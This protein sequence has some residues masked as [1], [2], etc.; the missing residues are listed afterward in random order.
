MNDF[1]DGTKFSFGKVELAVIPDEIEPDYQAGKSVNP[2]KEN[3]TQDILDRKMKAVD[4]LNNLKYSLPKN[5]IE[6]N[7][8]TI[9]ESLEEMADKI[10]QSS[11]ETKQYREKSGRTFK[12][13][14][15]FH[16]KQK[17]GN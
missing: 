13:K 4:A 14:T 6:A 17:R 15:N 1:K 12:N 11:C 9:R 2:H 10:K 5:M 3:T 16:K 8:A 7:Y